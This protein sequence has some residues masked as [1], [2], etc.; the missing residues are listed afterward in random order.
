MEN[1][2]D[3]SIGKEMKILPEHK[4]VYEKIFG[5]E[6]RESIY[7]GGLT[8]IVFPSYYNV[9]KSYLDDNYCNPDYKIGNYN[10]EVK[11]SLYPN[12][13]YQIKKR[14]LDK[15]DFGVLYWP[16]KENNTLVCKGVAF[17]DDIFK[18]GIPCKLGKEDGL[19]LPKEYF[20]SIKILNDE[21]IGNGINKDEIEIIPSSNSRISWDEY[22]KE[23]RN[24]VSKRATCDRGRSGCVI[25]KD[26]KILSTG[27]V[28]SPIRLEHCDDVGHLLR[29]VIDEKGN[30]SKHCIRT[31]HAEINAIINAAKT[32]TKID[33]STIY[34]SMTP[35]R[36]C[37]MAIIN[38][39]IKR[40]VCEKKYH[41]YK[42]AEEM[43]KKVGIKLE[44]EK[45]EIEKYPNQ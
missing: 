2:Y 19:S 32:G 1:E 10:I 24:V 16:N 35:C 41:E 27:Y 5:K 36:N 21:I 26:N 44:Y 39:G 28:G 17:K 31:V 20:K 18:K 13:C 15:I 7:Y 3:F 34:C 43:F 11:T 40:V 33:G 30:I 22:F 42:D 6:K 45:E 4:S 37:A 23:I 29:D 14:Q 12:A 38:A 9:P 25:E 8:N